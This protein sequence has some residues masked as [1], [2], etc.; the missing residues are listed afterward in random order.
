MPGISSLGFESKTS[1][2]IKEDIE[3][4]LKASFGESIDLTPQS[5]FGQ[6]VG[7]MTERLLDVWNMGEDVYASFD[8]DSASGAQLDALC[9][10]TGTIRE[11]ATQSE[12]TLTAVGDEGTTIP[13]GSAVSVESIGTRFLTLAEAELTAADA[14]QDTTAYVVGDIVTNGSSPSRVFRCITAGTSA[15]SGGPDEEDDDITDGTAHWEFLG[16][17]DSYA[18]IDAES[19]DTGPLV[20]A[21]GTLNVIESPVV[22]WDSVTNLLDADLGSDQETDAA[23]RLRRETELRAPGNASVEAI[24]NSVLDVEDVTTCT[25]FENP[26]ESTDVNGLPPHSI[27]V[28]VQGGED[29]DVAAAILA[30]KAAGIATDGSSSETVTDSQGIEHTIEFSRPTEKNI[31]VRVDLTYD[32][33]L[34][35][36][37]GDDQ[38]KA[39]IVAFG[40]AQRTGKDVV[41]AAVGAQAF[42]VAGVLDTPIVY[43]KKDSGPAVAATTVAIS[44]FELAVFDTSRIT[45]NSSAA[46]P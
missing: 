40:D 3:A 36:D 45:V 27:R 23:L 12:V 31:Y 16:E 15:G 46:T 10:I 35:P 13:E 41:A 39:A 32:A 24:R 9:G 22:G 26:T 17:G 25:V 21:A 11:A 7:L 42:S 4:A 38:V 20:A 43:I 34:Y 6:F 37:D 1:D 28:L 30:S 5:N 2:E 29:E 44:L 8:P 33:D 19:E 18:S 14:W